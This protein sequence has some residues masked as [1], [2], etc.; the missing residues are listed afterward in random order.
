LL[1]IAL[2]SASTGLAIATVRTPLSPQRPIAFTFLATSLG[3]FSMA[4]S[5]I[6]DAKGAK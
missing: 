1:V 4:S 2:R 6:A 5:V 3:I